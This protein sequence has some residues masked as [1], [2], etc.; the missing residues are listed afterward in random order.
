[1]LMLYKGSQKFRKRTQV[2]LVIHFYIYYI[3]LAH[4]CFCSS[5]AQLFSWHLSPDMN[6]ASTD[7]NVILQGNEVIQWLFFQSCSK[8]VQ[9]TLLPAFI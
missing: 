7:R 4:S 8:Q 2:L 1:M 5:F 9:N 3:L 6:T